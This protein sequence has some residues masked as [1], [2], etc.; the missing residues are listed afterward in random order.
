MDN[1]I[2]EIETKV[3][4]VEVPDYKSQVDDL[5]TAINMHEDEV[6][7]INKKVE[8]TGK[9]MIDQICTYLFELIEPFMD[10][11]K[12]KMSLLSPYYLYISKNNSSWSVNLHDLDGYENTEVTMLFEGKDLQRIRTCSKGGTYDAIGDRE[13]LKFCSS[14]AKSWNGIKRGV[15]DDIKRHFDLYSFNK[16]QFFELENE[17]EKD[18]DNFRI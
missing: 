14:L 2:I 13:R 12:F 17:Y 15:N 8:I 3:I 1:K 16:H 6:K 4:K 18:I 10:N 5:M 9:S 11:G 7:R